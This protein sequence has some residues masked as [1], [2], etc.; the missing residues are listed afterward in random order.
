VVIISG[1]Y[2]RVSGKWKKISGKYSRGSGINS[3]S[4][5]NNWK[6]FLKWKILLKVFNFTYSIMY[7]LLQIF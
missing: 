5:N 6:I 7:I 2:S 4:G 1:K 3:K